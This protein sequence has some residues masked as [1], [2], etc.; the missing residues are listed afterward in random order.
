MMT[1][2]SLKN[3]FALSLLIIF[4]N[5]QGFFY[6]NY[7]FPGTYLIAMIFLTMAL[8]PPT[9][10]FKKNE[11]LKWIIFSFIAIVASQIII[12]VLALDTSLISINFISLTTVI[13][14]GLFTKKITLQK[15][16]KTY[17]FIFL[18]WFVD[19]VWSSVMRTQTMN[20]ATRI[21]NG[22][23]PEAELFIINRFLYGVVYAIEICTT[24]SLVSFNQAP[25]L[26]SVAIQ[27]ANE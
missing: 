1:K 5:T 17:G 10:N 4:A 23:A 26:E 3:Y 14:L 16:L 8:L 27:E 20:S 11:Q 9:T 15:N 7:Y 13:G 25:Q 21:F 2:L 12:G 18:I 22:G 24:L 6:I 19:V